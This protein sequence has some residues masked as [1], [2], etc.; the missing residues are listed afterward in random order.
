MGPPSLICFLNFG[1]T[2]P[3]D[4]NTFPNLTIEKLVL[5]FLI[6]LCT[7]CMQSSESLLEA[8][9]ILVGLTALSLDIKTKI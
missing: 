6:C 8:P 7:D 3:E 1:I 2:E 5:I 9:I 4:S